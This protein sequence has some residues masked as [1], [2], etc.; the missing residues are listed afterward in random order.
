M[1]HSLK[2]HVRTGSR[3]FIR[4]ASTNTNRVQTDEF[5]VIIQLRRWASI[6]LRQVHVVSVFLF[7]SADFASSGLSG[8]SE[9]NKISSRKICR[10]NRI[11]IFK[12]VLA[13]TFDIGRIGYRFRFFP[14]DIDEKLR[15]AFRNSCRVYANRVGR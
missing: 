3:Q 5:F 4:R 2:F 7:F 6:K 15:R 12:F 9:T 14:A 11:F 13:E 1:T 8:Y 10:K